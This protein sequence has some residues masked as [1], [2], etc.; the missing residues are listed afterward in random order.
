MIKIGTL[1]DVER[2]VADAVTE[3]QRIKEAGFASAWATQIFGNDA[4]TLL[5]V[6]GAQVPEIELG[7]A[8]IPVYPRHPQVMAQQALTV[9]SATGGR[10]SLGIGLSHQ[11][12]VEGLWGY[13]YDRPGRYMAEYLDALV[14]MLKGEAS[15]HDG[16][17]LKAI[18]M[19]PLGIPGAEAPQLLVAALAPYML[20]LAGSLTD[21][22][23]TWMTGI[24]TIASHIGP[25]IAEA[26]A[27]AGRPSPR[28]VVSLPVCLTKD[29]GA[30]RDRI[31]ENFSIYPTLPSYAAM[32]EKEGASRPADIALVGSEEQIL[33][34]IGR[35]TEAGGTEL[36]AAIS[37]D[38][39]ER[40]ATFVFLASFARS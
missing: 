10:L 22:T 35:L 34:G 5:A 7:T 26:A 13:S 11:I 19:A 38:A 39:A 12:V 29:A 15:L 23:V 32:L 2:S 40:Q 36:V 8:V 31:D 17:V 27:E 33:D 28:I 20:K 18:T 24:S 9:Q 3:T 37:G 16:E 6:V 14:P 4:L 30:A 21:G 1:I 25:R